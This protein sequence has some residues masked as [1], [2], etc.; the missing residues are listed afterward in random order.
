MT[1]AEHN[2]RL[3]LGVISM[4]GNLRDLAKFALTAFFQLID[5]S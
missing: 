4:D 2:P 5:F 1:R 3:A